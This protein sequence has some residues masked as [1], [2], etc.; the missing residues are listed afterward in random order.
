[1]FGP[2]F[3]VKCV[4]GGS[5]GLH[6]SLL[7]SHYHLVLKTCILNKAGIGANVWYPMSV[8]DVSLLSLVLMVVGQKVEGQAFKRQ[9]TWFTTWLCS[10]K[11]QGSLNLSR[12]YE[13]ME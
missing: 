4:A 5:I 6:D 1:M 7:S 12:L 9:H 2:C 11:A 13:D 10:W 8:P 3:G